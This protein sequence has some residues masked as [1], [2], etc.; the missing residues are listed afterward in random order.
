MVGG[1]NANMDCACDCFIS[2]FILFNLSG[3]ARGVR[4]M[5]AHSAVTGT[6]KQI[7]EMADGT[8]RV[9][10]DVDPDCKKLFMTEFGEI[11]TKVAIALMKSESRVRQEK[12]D[13]GKMAQ[14]LH[15][16]GF[17]LAPLVCMA[18]GSDDQFLSWIKEHDFSATGKA[19][20]IDDQIV[21]AHVRRVANGSGT[22]IK[23][24]YS[25]IP[26]LNS[27]HQLQHQKGES[28][29]APREQWD[30]WRN[31]YLT[32]WCKSR[33]YQIFGI[34]TLKDLDQFEFNRWARENNVI[35]HVPVMWRKV[36]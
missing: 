35:Q 26:L 1:D 24:P 4:K 16:S 5:N 29:I 17:F 27:E 9:S 28:A 23:P 15:V 12:E 10:I 22:G 20:L 21:P 6:R 31:Q 33:M 8:I 32:D 18:L 13:S 30:K 34:E 7:K 14:A 3:N 11:D 25:A 19:E 2:L 36:A